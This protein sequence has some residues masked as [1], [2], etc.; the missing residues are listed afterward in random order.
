MLAKDLG[1]VVIPC[2]VVKEL[3]AQP[4]DLVLDWCLLVV[5]AE[6]IYLLGANVVQGLVLETGCNKSRKSH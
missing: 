5:G 4:P 3:A 2:D 1:D 6:V